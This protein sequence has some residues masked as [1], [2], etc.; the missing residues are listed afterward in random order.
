MQNVDCV[1]DTSTILR[2]H[3]IKESTSIDTIPLLKSK[4]NNL[5]ICKT[6]QNEL[7][8]QEFDINRLQFVIL[9]KIKRNTSIL[10]AMKVRGFKNLGEAESVTYCLENKNTIFLT[11]DFQACKNARIIIEYRSQFLI[12]YLITR[13]INYFTKREITQ[14]LK[15]RHRQRRIREKIYE[16]YIDKINSLY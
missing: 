9:P 6:V 13:G 14:I 1:L 8:N 12:S 4:F 10:R 2:C 16:R 11:D 5:T 15:E 3:K 7:L